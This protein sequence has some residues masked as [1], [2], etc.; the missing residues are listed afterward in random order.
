MPSVAMVKFIK[1]KVI[2]GYHGKD[3]PNKGSSNSDYKIK[4]YSSSNSS[5]KMGKTLRVNEG[6]TNRGRFQGLQIGATEITNRGQ[7]QEFL[8]ISNWGQ[9]DYKSGRGFHIRAKRFQIGTEIANRC[10]RDLK[11]GQGI[12]IGAEQ[13]QV[14]NVEGR[15]LYFYHILFI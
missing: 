4:S 5:T 9:K 10:K 11:S 3:V 8:G 2:F 12:E 7:L 15:M 13:R 1:T 14:L 6:I